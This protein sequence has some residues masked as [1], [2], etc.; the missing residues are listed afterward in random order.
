MIPLVERIAPRLY[1]ARTDRLIRARER[2][3]QDE[4]RQAVRAAWREACSRPALQLSH[5][6][7]I[8]GGFSPVGAPIIRE[9]TVGSEALGVPTRFVVELRPGQVLDDLQDSGR[10]LAQAFNAHRLRFARIGVGPLVEVEIIEDDPHA[11]IL[12]ALPAMPGYLVLGPDEFG[13][14][15]AYTPAELI[16]MAVQGSSGRGKSVFLLG[17]LRQLIR[18]P[19]VRIA[20]LDPSGVIFRPLPPDPW[21]ISGLGDPAGA[22]EV[23]SSLVRE[24]EDRL[25]RMPWDDDKLPCGEGHPDP[26]LFVVLEELPGLLAGL[27]DVDAKLGKRARALISRLAGEGRKVGVRL[28][29]LAQRFDAASTAGATVRNNCGLRLSFGVE[30]R[31]AVEFLHDGAPLD[32]VDEH[33]GAAPGVALVTAPG[34]S[35]RRIRAL[36]LTYREWAYAARAASQD[37][38]PV[39][40]EQRPAVAA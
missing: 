29:M 9:I 10:E 36:Y 25:T 11:G 1:H 8:A 35:V 26:W 12:D 7:T 38:A 13:E 17:I 24:M 34:M 15:V 20:G 4:I 40:V 16:H 3:V 27:D 31:A 28:V 14:P 22:V 19:G 33:V 30:N 18:M 37:E 5:G 6:G 39:E 21:R 23:L 2:I 32:V